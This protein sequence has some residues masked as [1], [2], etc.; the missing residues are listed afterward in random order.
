MR[1]IP[2]KY[3]IA[4]SDPHESEEI[5][6]GFEPFSDEKG[7]HDVRIVE[8]EPSKWDKGYMI[9]V[10]IFDVVYLKDDLVCLGGKNK[11]CLGGKNE[12]LVMNDYYI[13]DRPFSRAN[14]ICPDNGQVDM[15]AALARDEVFG[16][17]A[18][19]MAGS[20][21]IGLCVLHPLFGMEK[22]L[23]KVKLFHE[24]LATPKT[25]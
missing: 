11:I 1:K 20:L 10:R 21:Y 18:D 14:N 2:T 24:E 3:R 17:T 22:W 5:S 4:Y 19:R 16:V 6:P 15:I 25:R 13:Y 9:V 23:P 7:Y 8:L 12:I